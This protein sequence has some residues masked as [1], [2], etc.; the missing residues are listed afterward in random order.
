MRGQARAGAQ[1]RVRVGSDFE[2]KWTGSETLAT[3]CVLNF[4]L[5]FT[6]LDAKS[7]DF[8][9]RNGMTSVAAFNVLT[10]LEAPVSRCLPRLSP[11]G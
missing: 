2:R 11:N 8:V 5:T 1:P 9:L 6:M 4:H 3:E 10:I 7:R